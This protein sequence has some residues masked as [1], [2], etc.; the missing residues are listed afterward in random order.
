MMEKI[1][2]TVMKIVP[3]FYFY[4]LCQCLQMEMLKKHKLR[5]IFRLK[6]IEFGQSAGRG[7]I[8][9]KKKHSLKFSAFLYAVIK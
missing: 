4:P 1:L 3:I 8:K 6:P 2:I 7:Y 5:Y 9:K